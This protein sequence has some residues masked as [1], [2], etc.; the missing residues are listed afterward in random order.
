[1]S[2]IETYYRPLE[3]TDTQKHITPLLFHRRFKLPI[4]KLQQQ[5]TVNT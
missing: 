5:E 4:R 2:Q 1:M 3:H